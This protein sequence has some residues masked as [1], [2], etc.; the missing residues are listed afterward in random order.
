M[1]ENRRQE[2]KSD[3]LTLGDL[4]CEGKYVIPPYQR[5]YRW[6]VSQ[7]ALLLRDLVDYFWECVIF[8]VQGKFI[9]GAEQ[10]APLLF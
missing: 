2:F 3:K 10:F 8:R 7:V 4:L 9:G 6:G 5:P 1:S